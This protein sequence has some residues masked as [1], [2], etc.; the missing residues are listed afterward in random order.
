MTNETY[1]SPKQVASML[2]VDVQSVRRWIRAGQLPAFTLPGGT[3]WRVPKGAVLA[4]L[5]RC[6]AAPDSSSSSAPR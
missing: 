5:V 1:L 3:Q 6:P 2:S 4:M